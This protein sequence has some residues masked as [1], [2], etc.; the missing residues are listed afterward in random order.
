MPLAIHNRSEKRIWAD[1]STM[2]SERLPPSQYLMANTR[3]NSRWSTSLGRE[4]RQKYERYKENGLVP[5]EIDYNF[6]ALFIKANYQ[7]SSDR[8]IYYS[9]SLADRPVHFQNTT[10]GPSLVTISRD[11]LHS[12]ATNTRLVGTEPSRGQAAER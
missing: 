1:E 6:V 8:R 2:L 9:I 5:Q 3:R 7:F 4:R 12:L 10:L 11:L